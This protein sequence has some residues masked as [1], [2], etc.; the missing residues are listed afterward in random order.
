M[1][2]S[3]THLAMVQGPSSPPLNALEPTIVRLRGRGVQSKH[4]FTRFI[5]SGRR[6]LPYGVYKGDGWVLNFLSVNI[7]FEG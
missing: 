6:L 1:L 5:Q 3:R 7:N 2:S 4:K